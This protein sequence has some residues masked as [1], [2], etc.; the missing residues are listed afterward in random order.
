MMEGNLG[1]GD[2]RHFRTKKSGL[3]TCRNACMKDKRCKAFT[4]NKAAHH[5]WLKNDNHNPHNRDRNAISAYKRCYYGES[6]YTSSD[7]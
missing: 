6:V 1:G 7:L 4:Y 3:L 2:I 5:C